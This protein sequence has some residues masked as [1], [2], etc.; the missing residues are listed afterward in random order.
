MKKLALYCLIALAA[1]VTSVSCT[2][3]FLEV[4]YYS[5]V[6]P[7]GVYEDPN[8]VLMGLMGVYHTLYNDQSFYIKPHIAVANMPA[9]DLQAE[10]WDADM[11]THSWG[12]DMQS[13]FFNVGWTTHYKMVSRAN[14]YLADLENVSEDVVPAATKKVYE[15]EARFIRA[16]AYFFLTINFS[17]VPMLMTG[18]T[19][20]TAPEKAR[21]D[22][23]DEAW[24]AIK[25]DFEFAASVLDWKPAD[26]MV[27]R[28]TK[29]AALAYAAKCNM[30]LKDYAA[31]KNQLK[32]IIDESGRSLAPAYPLVHWLNRPDGHETIWEVSYPHFPDMGWNVWSFGKGNDFAFFSQQTRPDEYGGWGDAPLS[33]E[34]VRSFEPGDKRKNE[35]LGWYGEP[36][37]NPFTGDEI[38]V[39]GEVYQHYF[40]SKRAGI[41][42][43]HSMKWWKSNDVYTAVSVQLYRYAEV[44]LNYAE[45]AFRTGDAATGWN[46]IAQV[47]NRAWGN[48]EVGYDPNSDPRGCANS[49]LKFPTELL[50]T[51]V[52][53]VP[54]A[55][56]VYAKY[57]AEK[58]Y[59]SD[60]WVVA[61]TQERRKE[62]FY[63]FSFWFDLCRQELVEEWLECEYPKNG[64]A[65]FKNVVTGKLYVPTGSD[66]NQPYDDA[67]PEERAQMIPINPRDW[68]WNPIHLVY[69]IPNSEIV[70]NPL[71]EQNPGY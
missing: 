71:V 49:Y 1:A 18:E 25:E 38:G 22:S 2:D 55:Q 12:V 8:N 52:V 39:S 66:Y 23:D 37:K 34:L 26:G 42:N 10:G 59:H 43:N 35:I 6:N 5:I 29:A 19:Y 13:D 4:D 9:L 27:G 54:D 16:A 31:A 14:L 28:A 44:L 69:P 24:Q 62:F 20:A 45:C 68:D 21:P 36:A 3:K 51:E 50:N 7:D 11:V 47:R 32:Q 70:A 48:L 30:Y 56:E 40:Q 15:A 46:M 41:P 65:T 53:P 58:G 60:L 64:G 57:K 63:E 33:H 17:R 61:L 67:S